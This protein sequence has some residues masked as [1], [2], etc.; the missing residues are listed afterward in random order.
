MGRYDPRTDTW[1]EIASM[2]EARQEFDLEVVDCQ[3]FALGG[4]DESGIG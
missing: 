4:Y 3:M 2:H 1:L